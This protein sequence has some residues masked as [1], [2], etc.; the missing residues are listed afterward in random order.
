MNFP[1][2]AVSADQ[3]HRNAIIGSTRAARRAGSQQAREAV[4]SSSEMMLTRVNGSEALTG[5]T[6]EQLAA[7]EP[8]ITHGGG[9]PSD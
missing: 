7:G 2:P 8:E 1:L 4:A 6:V 9:L 5:G 3:S